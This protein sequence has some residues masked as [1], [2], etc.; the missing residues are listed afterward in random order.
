MQ[1]HELRKATE[2]DDT[3][4][5][6]RCRD[7]TVPDSLQE[8]IELFRY[9]GCV[10]QDPEDLFTEHSWVA[11]M[12]G[13]GI[14]PAGYDPLVDSLPLEGVRRFVRHVKDVTGKTAASMP[15]HEGFIEE[16]CRAVVCKNPYSIRSAS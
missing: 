13:Q 14:T 7:L 9:N 3:P 11:V 6:R 5:W 2:R 4:F 12:L 8:K 10:L 16:S 15:R 1:R